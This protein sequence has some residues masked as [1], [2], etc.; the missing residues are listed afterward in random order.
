MFKFKQIFSILVL[1]LASQAISGCQLSA[2]YPMVPDS[3]A[4]VNVDESGDFQTQAL[5]RK[6]RPTPKPTP[7]PRPRKTPKPKATPRPKVTPT[8]FV[9][10]SPVI[11]VAPTSGPEPSVFPSILPSVEPT[12][13]PSLA[14]SPSASP[15]YLPVLLVIANQDFYYREYAEPRRELL[16]AG[17]PVVV[18]ATERQA[19]YPHSGSGQGESSGEVMPDLRLDQV[20]AGDYSAIVF[21]GGW[22]S[23]QYQYAFPGQYAHAAYNGNAA[24]KLV[25]NQLINDFAAQNKYVMGICHGASVLAWARINGVS[26]LADRRATGGP[27]LP[28]LIGPGPTSTRDYIEGNGGI[29]VPSRSVGDPNTSADDLIVEGRFITAEDY[30]TA[31]LAGE[32]LA[33][34]LQER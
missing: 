13:S 12:S 10:P 19:S 23:S 1:A 20:T 4:F 26:P 32:T 34:L 30:D 24:T 21:V 33:Q 25:V 8:P 2:Q 27:W 28:E 11:S 17:I 5:K 7:T 22:G 31:E 29:Y 3:Q 9:V 18:A 6:V 16:A 14:P 15:A